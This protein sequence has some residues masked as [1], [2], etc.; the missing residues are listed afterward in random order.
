MLQN[1]AKEGGRALSVELLKAG[2]AGAPETRVGGSA[3]PLAGPLGGMTSSLPVSV[4]E[5]LL[6]QPLGRHY[7]ILS[8]KVKGRAAFALEP[9]WLLARG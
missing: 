4:T 9:S 7:A 1:S 3:P 5:A 8:L 6:F 2:Q